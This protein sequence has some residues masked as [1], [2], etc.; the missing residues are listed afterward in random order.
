MEGVMRF[1]QQQLPLHGWVLLGDDGHTVAAWGQPPASVGPQSEPQQWRSSRTG[2]WWLTLERGGRRWQL[3]IDRGIDSSSASAPTA[4]QQELLLTLV[5]PWLP[6][7]EQEPASTVERFEARVQAVQEAVARMQA[8]R[9]F[10]NASLSQMADGVVVVNSLGQIVLINPKAIACFGLHGDAQSLIGDSAITL[11]NTLDHNRQE[12]WEQ[13]LARPLLSGETTQAE[14]RTADGRD[15]LVQCAPLALEQQRSALVINLSDI[16]HL[17]DIERSRADTLR[18]LSHD[19]RAPLVSLLALADL[20]RTPETGIGQEELIK[21]VEE[22]A[23]TTLTLADEFLSLSQIEGAL[24]LELRPVE[25]TTVALNAIDAVWD[26]ARMKQITTTEAL[27][28]APLLVMADAAVLQRVL[29][30]LLGNA[31]KYSPAG[32]SVELAVAVSGGQLECAIQDQGCGIASDEI[33]RLCERFY[34]SR[35]A[36]DAGI[37]GTGLGLAFVKSAME[38]LGGSVAISSELGRGSRFAI[39]LPRLAE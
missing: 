37:P 27:P 7:R 16:T 3:G 17:L 33:P 14:A 12:R 39:R 6:A 13:L 24:Q 34:R 19:L 2:Q 35:S 25:F 38:K 5:Q 8:M 29:V 18:F 30:N 21:R 32:S 23:R 28:E 26:Q 9:R 10:I 4:A 31:I 11:L 1:V 22:H 20:A 15:L 36:I